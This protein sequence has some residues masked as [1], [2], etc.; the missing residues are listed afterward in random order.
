LMKRLFAI[1]LL[2]ALAATACGKSGSNQSLTHLDQVGFVSQAAARSV[3]QKTAKLAMTETLTPPSGQSGEPITINATGAVDFVKKVFDIK[4]DFP[5][6]MGI[7]GSIE[8]ILAGKTMYMQMPEA[9]RAQAGLSKPWLGMKIDAVGNSSLGN[10][11]FA[12]PTATLEALRSV[13]SSV[14]KVGEVTVRGVRTTKYAVVLDLTKIAEKVP[15]QYRAQM[16]QLKFNHLDVY[17]SDD[18]LVRRE[19]FTIGAAGASISANMDFYDY[20]SSVNVSA[21][22]ASQVEFKSLQDL[23]S[24]K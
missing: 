2:V 16:S 14:T 10:S 19:A 3:S 12:D 5:A 1:S 15:E 11:T 17:I 20:G 9:V 24:G 8:M 18:N 4:A 22:P 6:A 7:S 23:M 13:A 21:P